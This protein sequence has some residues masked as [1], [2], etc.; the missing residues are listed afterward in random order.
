MRVALIGCGFLG[1]LFAEEAARRRFAY[2]ESDLSFLYVDSDKFEER[3]FANQNL[4]FADVGLN[5]AQSLAGRWGN[6]TDFLEKRIKADNIDKGLESADLLVCAVDNVPTRTLLWEYAVRKG[7]PLLNMGIS[8]GGTG[9]VDWTAEKK[10]TNPFS[11][12]QIAQ[13]TPAQRKQLKAKPAQLPPCELVAF[14]GLGLNTAL[15]AAKAL[16][17][18]LGLDAEGHVDPKNH[19][20][21][22]GTVTIWL[23]D[24]TSHKLLE[25]A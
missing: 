16:F 21:E 4:T 18:Y 22:Y 6:E 5:K 9:A 7:K 3:N 8:Q 13:M 15:A 19:H 11:G 12:I 25:V 17:I 1:S 20:P 10:D 14:R 24:N 2:E 23:A